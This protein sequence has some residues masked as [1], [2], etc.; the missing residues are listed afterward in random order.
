MKKIL[1]QSIGLY[2]NTLTRVAPGRGGKLGFRLFCK[3][4]R[5]KLQQHHRAFL[6]TAR[7]S[8]FDFNGIPIR[9]YQWGNGPKKVLFVHGWQSH[10]FRWKKYVESLSPEEYTMIA[11]DA[12]GH[13]LSG[14]NQFTVPLNAYLIWTLTERYQ[15]F[16]TV[17]AHSIGSISVLYALAYYD[18]QT[19]GQVVSMASRAGPRNFSP[20]TLMP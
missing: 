7:Q 18:I 16:D 14:G 10:S 3:P 1:Y 19:I 4:Q 11:F 20:I 12:P 9:I 13:G 8:S 2:L 5:S 15:G 6:R 17:V